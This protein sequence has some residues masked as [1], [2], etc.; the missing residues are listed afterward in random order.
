MR[1]RRSE[2]PVSFFAFQDIMTGII[3]VMIL[4]VLV[5]VLGITRMEESIKDE[6]SKEKSQQPSE[7]EVMRQQVTTLEKELSQARAQAEVLSE[8]VGLQPGRRLALLRREL[9]SLYRQIEDQK[10]EIAVSTSELQNL[11]ESETSEDAAT[12]RA[13]LLQQ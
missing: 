13:P 11:V 6:L 7:V 1:R 3:G 4:V 9:Q 5:L 2:S 12:S 8:M 10:K